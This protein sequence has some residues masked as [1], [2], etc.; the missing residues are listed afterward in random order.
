MLHYEQKGP[1]FIAE[2]GVKAMKSGIKEQDR[3]KYQ[4]GNGIAAN[5]MHF[6]TV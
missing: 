4:I 5:K 2:Y 1:Y 6:D 3:V